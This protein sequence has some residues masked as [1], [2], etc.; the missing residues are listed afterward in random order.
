MIKDI[1]LMQCSRSDVYLPGEMIIEIGQ[2]VDDDCL[3]IGNAR[4][5]FDLL[6]EL[7]WQPLVVAVEEGYPSTALGAHAIV[8]RPRSAEVTRKT[9]KTDARI[10]ERGSHGLRIVGRAVVNN[11]QLEV[12][13]GLSDDALDGAAEKVRPVIYGNDNADARPRRNY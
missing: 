11:D 10:A 12:G 3:R 9:K 6:L 1:A 4:K 8:A 2:A 7:D 13:E 5:T